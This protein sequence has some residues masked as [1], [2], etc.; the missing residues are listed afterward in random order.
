VATTAMSLKH[1]HPLPRVSVVIP[2]LNEARNI[3]HVLAKMPDMVDEIV[4]VDGH[5]IDDTVDVARSAWP[6]IV[7]VNQNRRGKGNALACGF[8][9]A[10]G[11]VI[12]MID[13]DCS[14][15]PLEIPAFV[16]ALLAGADY[17]KGSRFCAGGG[18]GDITRIRRVGNRALNGVVNTLFRTRFSDLCYGYNAFWR[19]ALTS[20]GLNTHSHLVE[21]QWGDGFEIE[22]MINVRVARA[23]LRIAEVPSFEK[24]RLHGDS[25]LKAVRDGLRVLRT[26]L[27]ER[28]R[29]A[30]VRS[31]VITLPDARAS[32]HNVGLLPPNAWSDGVA[33]S[34]DR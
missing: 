12:V 31:N 25:N 7:V 22:T 3:A 27:N 10:T 1:D 14:T 6:G 20:M 5:S 21:P 9:A 34:E 16:S 30:P 32:R 26:V 11:D 15:D 29:A 2:T 19:H 4:L 18:S 17:A 28:M 24:P 13:A 23:G 8:A 33:M